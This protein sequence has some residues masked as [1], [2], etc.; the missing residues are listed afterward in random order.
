MT[1]FFDEPPVPPVVRPPLLELELSEPPL[2]ELLLSEPPLEL[3][4]LLELLPPPQLAPL[5]PRAPVSATRAIPKT[6]MART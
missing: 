1:L 5:E 6:A 3:L 2:L 4:E